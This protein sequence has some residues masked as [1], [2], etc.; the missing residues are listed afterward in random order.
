MKP[1][2]ALLA[3]AGAVT[4]AHYLIPRASSGGVS[5]TADWQFTR[6]TENHYSNGPV[7]D[8]TSPQMTCYELNPGTPAP[9]TLPV[10]AGGTVKFTIAP[11]IYHPGPVNVYMAKAPSSAANFDGKGNV[12]FKIWGDAPKITSS[13]I[14]FPSN[15]VSEMEIPIPSCIANGEYL[16]RFEQTGLHSASSINGAQ[17]Y[18]SCTQVSVT[19]GTGTYSPSLMSFPGAYSATDPG[20]LINIYW[21]IPTS[22]TSPGGPAL[23][24]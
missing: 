8:V 7:T 20:L 9:Q 3:V 2:F 15:G 24:C 22:Y 19:G 17:L 13:S 16:I 14:E 23:K 12:W 10:R 21:P 11:N 4:N 5:A 1:S 6:I 18:L